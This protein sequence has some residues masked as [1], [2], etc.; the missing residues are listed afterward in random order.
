[1]ESE[2]PEAARPLGPGGRRLAGDRRGGEVA[3]GIAVAAQVEVIVPGSKEATAVE[4]S[5][6]PAH[7]TLQHIAHFAGLQMSKARKDQL[8]PAPVPGAIK[9]FRV[10]GA[11]KRAVWRRSSAAARSRACRATM[12]D[13]ARTLLALQALTSRTAVETAGRST[14]RNLDLAFRHGDSR[15]FE[16]EAP[17]VALVCAVWGPL[18]VGESAR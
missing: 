3:F 13:G 16:G 1:M 11:D 7:R 2:R 17:R 18:I 8:V 12:P 4:M 14:A 5:L 15:K 10:D 9:W 6:D